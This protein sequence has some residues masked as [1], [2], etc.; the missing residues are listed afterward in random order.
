VSR[1]AS[2]PEIR[3]SDDGIWRR[4]REV[5]FTR[6]FSGPE[7]DKELMATLLQELP[8]ILNWAIE[9]SLLWQSE[10][11]SPPAS[12][13]ESTQDYRTE[14]DTVISFL[15]E[16]CEQNPVQRTSVKILYEN[17]LS[18][19]RSQDRHPRT[20]VQFGKELTSKGYK[21]V[22][23]ICDRND[24]NDRVSITFP[25]HSHGEVSISSSFLSLNEE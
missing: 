21:Q 10:G 17:Y 3:G 20:K 5:P 25:N 14:M 15:E 9:G 23:Y 7:Q 16:E 4:V 11:L 2:R 22:T 6:N 8:G 13:T 12:V 1:S 18:W 19:C 24:R